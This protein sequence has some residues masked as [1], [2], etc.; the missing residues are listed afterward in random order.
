MM[1]S[2]LNNLILI[3]DDNPMN[4]QVLAAVLTESGY[5]T[6]VAMNGL[7]ALEFLEVQQPALI[8]LDIM[9]PEMDGFEVCARVKGNP[10]Y[11]DIPIIFLT[12]KNEKEDILKAFKTG[13]VDYIIKPFNTAELKARI[14]T[15]MELKHSRDALLHLNEKIQ[16]MNEDLELRVRERTAKLKYLMDEQAEFSYAIAHDLRS[17]LRAMNGFSR[18]LIDDYQHH[19]DDEGVQ[20]LHKINSNSIRIGDLIDQLL[21]YSKLSRSDINPTLVDMNNLVNAAIKEFK[22]GLKNPKTTFTVEQLPSIYA[23]ETMIRDA[24]Q[25]L[26]SNAIKFSEGCEVPVIEIGAVDQDHAVEF[27]IR[28]NGTGFDMAFS[29]KL[30]GVFQ[31]LHGMNEYEG[32]GIGLTFVKAIVTKHNGKIRAESQEGEGATFY[33]TIPK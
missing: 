7:Q 11:S 30:F 33:F 18:F 25:Y 31:R 6:G 22:G 29:N 3:V 15:H 13:G 19:L 26:L 32:Y 24:F 27:F 5:Q 28:D 17:P 21:A 16:K 23:D 9:M 10:L 14:S 4:I 12:A 20:L 1:D 2:E 8:L